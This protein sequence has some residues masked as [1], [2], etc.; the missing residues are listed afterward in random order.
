M[1]AM[2]RRHRPLLRRQPPAELLWPPGSGLPRRARIR[3]LR[4]PH[5]R[6]AAPRRPL[7][8]GRAD[9]RGRPPQHHGL[10]EDVSSLN[11]TN[12]HQP[13]SGGFF[14]WGSTWLMRCTEKAAS[15]SETRES[16]GDLTL[17]RPFWWIPAHTPFPLI[18]TTTWTTFLA[19]RGLVRRLRWP[20]RRTPWAC[21]TPP[22]SV[23]PV[24][25]PHLPL[26]R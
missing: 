13:P 1:E 14:I 7:S 2:G 6:A 17:S 11:A 21:W 12:R 19:E 9:H 23:S 15:L 10:R 20:P 26:R 16:T 8:P 24:S 3:R 4:R 25:L 5:P 22:T 18:P